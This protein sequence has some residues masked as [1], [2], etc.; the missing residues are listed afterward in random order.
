MT[1]GS[2]RIWHPRSA[3]HARSTADRD[4]VAIGSGSEGDSAEHFAVAGVAGC[5]EALG[6]REGGGVECVCDG[7]ELVGVS[8]LVA[9][10]ADRRGDRPDRGGAVVV[11]A[12]CEV[13]ESVGRW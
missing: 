13:A 1:F 4:V 8:A 6:V 10:A 12:P 11:D 7:D 9:V 2:P 5:G 3:E